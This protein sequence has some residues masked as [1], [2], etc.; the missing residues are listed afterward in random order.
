MLDEWQENVLQATMGERSDGKWATPQVAISAPRQQGKSQLIVA[1]ALAGVLLF[2]E[3][4]IIVSAHQQDT[5]REVF[6][7]MLDLIESH[8]SLESRVSSVMRAL[9]REFISFTSGQSIRFKARS[10][11]G[12]RGFSCDC[13]LLDEAQILS[14]AAWSAILP[15]MSARPNPQAWLL[16]TPPTENDDGEVFGRFRKRG[17]EGK[18][19]RL[20]YLEWSAS[21]GDDMDDPATWAKANPAY[22]TRISHEAIAGERATMSDAQFAMER[23]GIWAEDT[24]D[25]RDFLG[26]DRWRELTI[27]AAE[28]DWRLSAVGL[29]MDPDSGRLWVAPAALSDS[30]VHVELL[31]DDLLAQGIDAAVSWLYQRVHRRLPVVIPA[32][33]PATVLVPA[34]LA[35]KVKVYQLNGP[36]IAQACSTFETAIRDGKVSHLANPVLEA[37]VAESEKESYRGAGQYRIKRS[38]EFKAAPLYA[39][40]CANFGAVKWARTP[41][42]RRKVVVLS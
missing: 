7:R 31:P 15:T 41:R 28:D 8:K 3:K 40:L 21:P 16:G 22:G 39:A 34:L 5:A 10:A 33:S 2:D 27:P 19:S 32:E 25:A 4:T 17:I 18:E 14:Q 13:L 1:R 24:L 42:E 12:G 36:E 38:G 20:A 29:D 23:L 26:V 35:R 6:G 37:C 11:G 9:N 30:G